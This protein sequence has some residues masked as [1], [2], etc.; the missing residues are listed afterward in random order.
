MNAEFPYN[1]LNDR[2]I[3]E[4]TAAPNWFPNQNENM[5]VDLLTELVTSIEDKT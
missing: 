1:E 4:T 2:A 3:N 5:K